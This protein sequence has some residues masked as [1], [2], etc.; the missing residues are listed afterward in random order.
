MIATSGFL[1]ALECTEFVFGRGSDPDQLTTPPD[2]L[3]G[4]RSPTS[5]GR[6]GEEKGKEKEKGRGRGREGPAPFSHIPGSTPALGALKESIPAG[7]S[8]E[9]SA[10]TS[11]NSPRFHV[12]RMTT[13]YNVSVVLNVCIFLHGFGFVW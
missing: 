13:D 6:K 8:L 9:R 10:I 2:L 5:Q 4:L 12:S 7:Y 11:A 3:A 1:A